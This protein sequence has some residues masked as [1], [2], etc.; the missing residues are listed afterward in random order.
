MWGY[1]SLPKGPKKKKSR[2]GMV[3]P[4]LEPI[5]EDKEVAAPLTNPVK[6]P[7]NDR[8]SYSKY[9]EGMK[10]SAMAL[11]V[12][13]MLSNGGIYAAAKKEAVEKFGN[14]QVSFPE[15]PSLA[16]TIKQ[17]RKQKTRQPM[18]NMNMM[19]LIVARQ[20]KTSGA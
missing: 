18:M 19:H 11:M 13:E 2:P 16:D 4:P 12:T 20:M 7:G 15:R 1:M 6:T 9:D 5:S 8:G 14:T 17:R 3:G 10:A